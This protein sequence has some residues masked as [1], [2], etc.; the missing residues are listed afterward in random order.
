V[1]RCLHAFLTALLAVSLLAAPARA[2]WRSRQSRPCRPVYAMPS[3]PPA[4]WYESRPCAGVVV[5]VEQV[6]QPVSV[7]CGEPVVVAET[8]A[9]ALPTVVAGEAEV[10]NGAA[11]PA[12]V[13]DRAMPTPAVA[14]TETHEPGLERIAPPPALE[15]A[16]GVTPAS[17]EQPV[18]EPTL[19][20]PPQTDAVPAVPDDRD[21]QEDAGEPEGV[22][23]TGGSTDPEQPLS[24]D[25]AA[26]APAVADESQPNEPPMEEAV[27][28]EEP[29]AEP[30]SAPSPDPEPAPAA[31]PEPAPA[32]EPD[33]EPEPAAEPEPEPAP[34][35]EPEPAPAAEPDPEPEPGNIFD[36][37]DELDADESEESPAGEAAMAEPAADPFG[38]ESAGADGTE[39]PEAVAEDALAP[40]ADELDPVPSAGAAAEEIIE[41]SEPEAVP[42]P[43][44]AEPTDGDAGATDPFPA[45]EV[46]AVEAEEQPAADFLATSEPLR[47]WIDATGTASIVA[48]LV[49][50]GEGGCVLETRGRRVVVP[51]GKL[52]Q[53]DRDYVR[54][55][56][57]RLANSRSQEAGDTAAA[58]AP[59]PTDTA[60]L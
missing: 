31:D 56:G 28:A 50:V 21:M 53:H 39:T 12:A 45:A 47:R 49:D 24:A 17:N 11:P 18:L 54:R 23:G 6:C 36:E 37:F 55:A 20:G 22:A 29:P 7:C 10:T 38:E 32:A 42:Q 25:A 46:P 52:S 48:T 1:R 30:P 59:A 15:P 14:E 43:V 13:A 41:N 40:A 44:E 51:F 34:P 9:H 35:A 8:H 57:I 2:C 16:G 3:C 19:A 4:T 26:D 58:A 27:A 5:V 33:P 60:G